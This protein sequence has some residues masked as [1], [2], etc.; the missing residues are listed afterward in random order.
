MLANTMIS[1]EVNREILE[2]EL[3]LKRLSNTSIFLKDN[4]FVVSPSVQNIHKW[5]DFRKVNLNRFKEKAYEG[6][7]LI[8]FFDKFLLI[9]L[10]QFVNKMISEEKFVET[11]SIGVHWKF[12]IEQSEK[13]YFLR[14]RQDKTCIQSINEVTIEELKNHF[15]D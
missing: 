13:K 4:F 9:E 6:F 2:K 10:N 3:G 1:S 14:S 7:L 11:K 15:N 5:F 8:R 12:N